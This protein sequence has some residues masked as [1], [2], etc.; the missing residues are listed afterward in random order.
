MTIAEKLLSALKIVLLT[1]VVTAHA[2]ASSDELGGIVQSPC[3]EPSSIPLLDFITQSAL[4][5]NQ[6]VEKEDILA[7]INKPEFSAIAE[8]S[9]V[10]QQQDW[11]YLC[12]YKAANAA[13]GNESPKVVFMGDSITENWVVAQPDFFKDGLVGRGI[14]GQTTPQMLVRFYSDV[15]ALQPNAVHIMAGTNDIAG[16]TGPITLQDY[17]N[18]ILAMIDLAKI[19]DIKVILAS[20]PPVS[21]YLMIDNFEPRP[22]VKKINTWLAQVAKERHLTFVDYGNVLDDG[23][24]SMKDELTND[25]V[26]PTR[27]GYDAM[28]PLTVKAIEQA[29]SK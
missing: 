26:H 13:L 2:F 9:R 8:A 14:S 25:E 24:G 27:A 28:R 1:G 17:K 4:A 10:Q 15:V 19:H 23:H 7:I 29:L 18:N 6:R 12:K 16:N 11:A 22:L 21:K 3:A 20:V 5:N